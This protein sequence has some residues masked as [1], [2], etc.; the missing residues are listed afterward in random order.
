VKKIAVTRHDKVIRIPSILVL[1]IL[2][3]NSGVIVAIR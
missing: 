1:L 3:T 2:E